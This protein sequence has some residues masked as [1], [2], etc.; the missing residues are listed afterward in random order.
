MDRLRLA[1]GVARADDEVVGVARRSRAGRGCGSR[2]PSCRRRS[3]RSGSRAPPARACRV[4]VPSPPSGWDRRAVQALRADEVRDLVRHEIADRPPRRPP[5]RA[6]LW[7]TRR[8]AACRRT[9]RSASPADRLLD[10]R[11]VH[12]RPLGHRD[13][14]E[15]H[16]LVG[17]VPPRQRGGLVAAEDQHELV[18]GR[19][20]PELA[21]RVGRVRR[22]LAVD[23]DPR[24]VEALVARGRVARTSRSAPRLRGPAGSPGAAR[25]RPASRRTTSSSSW[26]C[27]SC[28][29]TR[30]P[31]C[32]GLNAPPKRPIRKRPS[33]P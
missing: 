9:R 28:A 14:R 22:A 5:A 33:T 8:S 27:A 15:P 6:P 4:L 16:H 19:A 20:R 18:A 7:T 23:L 32:G 1:L 21:E 3:P 25:G 10:A 24:Q 29:Q 30:C 11:P 17:L 31:T 13:R 26:A 2:P 12:L